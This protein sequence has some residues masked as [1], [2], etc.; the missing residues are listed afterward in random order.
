M[1]TIGGGMTRNQKGEN[2][3]IKISYDSH[4]LVTALTRGV[5]NEK[6]HRRACEMVWNGAQ[7]GLREA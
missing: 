7:H 6:I 4:F 2:N 3:C 1:Q 5:W